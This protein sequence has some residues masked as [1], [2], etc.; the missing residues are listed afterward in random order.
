MKNKS[1]VALCLV[2]KLT[3]CS[4]PQFWVQLSS[5]WLIA[6]AL[7]FPSIA[8]VVQL[9]S[10]RLRSPHTQKITFLC[11]VVRVSSVVHM[12]SMYS[13]DELGGLY[14]APTISCFPFLVWL[15]CRPILYWSQYRGGHS[16][17]LPSLQRWPLDSPKVHYVEGSLVRRSVSPKVPL[18][19]GPLVRTF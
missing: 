4:R 13:I 1:S 15:T 9:M 18:S 8:W 10:G 14:S 16:L 2:G 17:C 12:L 7:E 6:T 19:E 11:L 3:I 5:L